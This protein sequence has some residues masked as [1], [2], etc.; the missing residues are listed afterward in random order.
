MS[1]SDI[2][3]LISVMDCPESLPVGKR[4]PSVVSEW[5]GFLMNMNN[6]MLSPATNAIQLRCGKYDAEALKMKAT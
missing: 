2:K 6:A 5:V 1:R 4:L 3:P